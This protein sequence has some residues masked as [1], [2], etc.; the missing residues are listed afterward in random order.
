MVD[1]SL[2]PHDTAPAGVAGAMLRKRPKPGERRVQILETL[3][4]MLEQPGAD[5]VTTAAL[6]AKLSVSEA[7]LYRHFASKAQM[8]EGLIEFIE[9]SVF[10]LINQVV[11]RESDPR[12]QAARIATVVLQFGEKNPGMTRVMVGDALVFE[13]E[14]LLVRMNQF[15]ERVESQLRQ[16]MRQAAEAAGSP[17]PTVEGNARASVLTAFIVGRLQRY[18]RSN[19]KRLATEHLDVAIAQLAS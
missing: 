6:A 1:T 19:F 15:F 11:E 14:R 9:S 4:T 13:N 18:A 7:A 16:S 10:S 17:A 8:F 3:A 2:A 12:A 5:R